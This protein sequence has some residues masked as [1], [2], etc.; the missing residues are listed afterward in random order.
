VGRAAGDDGAPA[1]QGPR[2][3]LGLD[4]REYFRRLG[5]APKAEFAAGHR[6][7]AR[8]DTLHAAALEQGEV[9][10][11][12]W[13]VP[14]API[15]RRRDQ[16]RL[17]AGQQGG[18]GEIV[19]EA[20]RHLGDDVR[21][22]RRHDDEVG[23]P[24]QADMP[25]LALVGQGEELGIDLVL[26][27]GCQRQGGH[28]LGPAVGQDAAHGRAPLA[29]PADE[30]QGLVGGDPAGN[31]EKN[32]FASQHARIL[33]ALR[34]PAPYGRMGWFARQP[35][36]HAGGTPVISALTLSRCVTTFVVSA[37]LSFQL[38]GAL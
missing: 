32:S 3:Q 38:A 35:C 33:A 15:H 28:E 27:E 37:D 10:L 11:R 7:F 30:L 13:V 4:D 19:G 20:L 17:V 22:R 5:H 8:P 14:H 21:G 18:R 12:G 2:N 29:Q 6:P 31:D 9:R 26:A 24:A 16:R 25:H 36:T 23:L 34:V 1:A